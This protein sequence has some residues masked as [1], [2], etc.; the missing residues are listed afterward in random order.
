ML[1][2]ERHEMI[3]RLVNEKGS[4]RV[5]E[6]SEICNVTEETIRRDLDRLEQAGR[7]LRSHGGAVSVAEQQPEDPYMEREITRMEEK[8]RIAQEA[9]KY[10]EPRDRIILDASTTAWYMASILPDIP[11]T[12][13]TNSLKVAME[14]STKEKIEVISTGGIMSARSLSFVGPSAERSLDAYHVNKAFLSCKGVHL[15]RGI[16]ESNE[17]QALVKRKM[18]SIADRVL[19]LADHS[20]FGVQAFTYFAELSQI[21]EIITDDKID[22]QYVQQLEE[23]AVKLTVALA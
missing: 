12:V 8:K 5:S 9:I 6:L 11:L 19:L 20:K 18:I 16:S 4:M 3:V 7:L 14:L 1:V 15:G 21:D 2:I 23:M 22:P 10:I 17:M 13:L